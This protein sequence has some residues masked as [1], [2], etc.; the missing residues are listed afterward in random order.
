MARLRSQTTGS[1]SNDK[2]LKVCSLA[3][4]W[5]DGALRNISTEIEAENNVKVHN[6]KT[7]GKRILNCMENKEVKDCMFSKASEAIMMDDK[8]NF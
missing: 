4:A 8:H 2:N 5:E 7:V 3:Q 1:R 6:A